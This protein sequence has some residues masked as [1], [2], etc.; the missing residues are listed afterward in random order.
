MKEFKFLLKYYRY[1]ALFNY[2]TQLAQKLG[3]NIQNKLKD[4]ESQKSL[5]KINY[6]MTEEF[7]STD[8]YGIIFRKFQLFNKDFCKKEK[9]LL[10]IQL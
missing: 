8:Q 10:I 5:D 2:N 7:L 6:G 3:K 9:I 4:N 1:K